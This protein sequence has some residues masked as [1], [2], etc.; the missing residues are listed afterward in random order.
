MV[1]ALLLKSNLVRGQAQP[2]GGYKIDYNLQAKVNALI[3]AN[4]S[5]RVEAASQQVIRVYFHIMRTDDG[6][7]PAATESQLRTEYE[8]LVADYNANNICFVNAGFDTLNSSKLDTNFNAN[9]DNPGLFT[10]FL[11]PNCINI[12]YLSKI[13]GNNP[14]CA[15][16]CGI[17]GTSLAIPNNFCLISKNN[18]GAGRTVSHEVGHCL[19]LLHTFEPANGFENIDGSNSSTA[20]DQITDTPADPYAYVGQSC[21]SVSGC[22]YNGSCKDPN[23]KTNFTP[24]YTNMMAYWWNA[25]AGCYP[26]LAFSAGQN[27][28]VDAY[29]ASTPMLQACT[30]TNYV[31]LNNNSYSSGYFMS[32]AVYTLTAQTNVQ[33]SGS[34]NVTLGGA[35]VLLEPGF[36]AISLTSGHVLIRTKACGTVP[37]YANPVI[38]STVFNGMKQFKVDKTD[39][40]I[41][42]AYPN[43]ASSGVT[44]SFQ[45]AHSETHVEI[46]LYDINMRKVKQVS[47]RNI[48]AGR[49]NINLNTAGLASGIYFI[50]LRTSSELLKTKLVIEK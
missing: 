8:A 44:L 45:L 2:C 36:R 41:L 39:V 21:F 19:G 20:A 9:T 22:T 34:A 35:T 32:S 42:V 40:G 38:T 14:A 25:A 49:N 48:L 27:A 6:K 11:V 16:G 46:D 24:P 12:F 30:S 43:P 31:T 37:S 7:L 15:G 33:I 1:V 18:I 3:A 26:S 50:V 23:N 10:P 4:K 29:L 13:K 17:G 47:P 28:R 5:Q